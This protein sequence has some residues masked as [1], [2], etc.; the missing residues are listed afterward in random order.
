PT[1]PRRAPI[2]PPWQRHATP[3]PRPH[4][5]LSTQQPRQ[6]QSVRQTLCHYALATRTSRDRPAP[7]RDLEGRRSPATTGTRFPAHLRPPPSPVRLERP[8]TRSSPRTPRGAK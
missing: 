2:R 4:H 1:W 8:P 5:H 3:P 7:P 6:P